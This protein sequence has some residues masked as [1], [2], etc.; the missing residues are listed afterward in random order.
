MPMLPTHL[1]E[2]AEG[3]SQVSGAGGG[4]DDLGSVALC[5]SSL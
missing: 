4:G 2:L 5:T 1:D 3:E